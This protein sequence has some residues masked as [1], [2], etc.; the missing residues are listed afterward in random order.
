[1]TPPCST[2]L[3]CLKLHQRLQLSESRESNSAIRC[4]ITSTH[5]SQDIADVHRGKLAR[6]RREAEVEVDPHHVPVPAPVNDHC[7]CGAGLEERLELHPK[8]EDH[9]N[10]G[11]NGQGPPRKSGLCQIL[12]DPPARKKKVRKLV[13]WLKTFQKD[14]GNSRK[15]GLCRVLWDPPA[16]RLTIG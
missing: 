12:R 10:S 9:G 7:G 14:H 13:R 8:Q 4:S 16:Y 3:K 1:M 2:P 5:C 6:E 15:G 11:N